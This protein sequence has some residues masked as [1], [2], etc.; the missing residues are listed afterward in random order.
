MLI[1]HAR[2]LNDPGLRMRGIHPLYL[3]SWSRRVIADA[4]YVTSMESPKPLKYCEEALLLGPIALSSPLAPEFLD[5]QRRLP[6]ID[7]P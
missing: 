1:G 7:G 4:L 2:A 6:C 5:S 3:W